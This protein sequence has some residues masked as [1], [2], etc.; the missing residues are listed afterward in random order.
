MKKIMLTASVLSAMILT[1]SAQQKTI[2]M[3]K[4]TGTTV[5]IHAGAN[6]YNI[7]GK[8]A[9]GVELNNKMNTGFSAGAD[10]AIPHVAA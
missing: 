6:M 5:G 2:S 9:N 8:L 4:N 1:A 3:T 10:V 7:N